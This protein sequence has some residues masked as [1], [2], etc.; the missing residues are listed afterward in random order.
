MCMR[1]WGQ[2][3]A[4]AETSQG[5]QDEESQITCET[6]S[7]WTCLPVSQHVSEITTHMVT[8]LKYYY[9]S[10][11]HLWYEFQSPSSSCSWVAL[12]WLS[13]L[14]RPPALPAVYSSGVRTPSQS[15][16]IHFVFSKQIQQKKLLQ[17][18][19]RLQSIKINLCQWVVHGLF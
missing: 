2:R 4:L 13:T 7:N 3:W 5:D 18:Q 16:Q 1:W 12:T 14:P 10:Q 19:R 15:L 17:Q 9:F 8:I 6:P 11:M